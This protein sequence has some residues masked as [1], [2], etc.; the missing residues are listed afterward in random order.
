MEALP[1]RFVA[2]LA[3]DTHL[4]VEVK[5]QPGPNSE[6][7]KRYTT[8]WWIPAVAGTPAL[9]HRRWA[10][11]ELTNKNTMRD[12]LYQTIRDLIGKGNP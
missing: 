8:E 2:R 10:F 5:G 12:E 9:P 6:A 7:K 11:V 4:I 3:D 1:P